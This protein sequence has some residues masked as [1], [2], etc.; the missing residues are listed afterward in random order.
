MQNHEVLA[1]LGLTEHEQSVYL[2]LL[3]HGVQKASALSKNT[4]LHRPTVYQTLA[5]LK[6]RGLVTES[7]KGKQKTYAAEP[8]TKLEP[9]FDSFSSAFK[10]MIPDLEQT[11]AGHSKKPLVKYLEGKKGI[12][13]IWDDLVHSLKHDEIFYR[14]SSKPGQQAG[15]KYL[16]A[17]YR[18]IRDAKHLQRFVITSPELA[19]YKKPRLERAIKVIPKSFGEFDFG[20]TV[21]IYGNKVAYIDYNSETAFLIES[22]AIAEFQKKL[23]K[24]N[25]ELLK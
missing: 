2:S 1:H 15:E 23:F 22:A 20:V 19:G 21:L 6:F 10:E 12:V 5:K 16:P 18:E 4:S 17:K 9:I 7:M 8:P 25:Y 11:F 24:I 3:E 13:W 14:Y